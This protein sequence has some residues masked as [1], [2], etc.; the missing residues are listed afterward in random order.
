MTYLCFVVAADVR[1]LSTQHKDW[2]SSVLAAVAAVKR[3]LM[4]LAV[5]AVSVCSLV[6]WLAWAAC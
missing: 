3:M 5:A 6:V 2:L 1:E 4:C